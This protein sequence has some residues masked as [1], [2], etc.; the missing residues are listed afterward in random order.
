M[1]EYIKCETCLYNKNCQFLAKHR[2][3]IVENCSAYKNAAD[4]VEVVHG[5]WIRPTMINGRTFDI[6]HCSACG[7]VPCDTKNYCPN[8]GADMRRIEKR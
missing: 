4:V 8:C 6:P 5:E 7:D 1:A 3:T 2:N